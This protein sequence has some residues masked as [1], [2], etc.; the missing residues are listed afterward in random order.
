MRTVLNNMDTNKIIVETKMRHIESGGLRMET[1]IDG[2]LSEVRQTTDEQIKTV[3]VD[4]LR[5]EGYTIIP[6]SN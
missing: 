1:W 3:I 2:M 5:A 4:Y 6:P